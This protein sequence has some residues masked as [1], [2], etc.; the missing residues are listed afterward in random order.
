M[1][2]SSAGKQVLKGGHHFAD[3]SDEAA[4]QAIVEA[5]NAPA[6]I[7]DHL[8]REAARR[9]RAKA[10]TRGIRYAVDEIR[11]RFWEADD[12]SPPGERARYNDDSRQGG[13]NGTAG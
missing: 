4:A 9:P 13:D 12:P 3:A 8:E 5:M 10:F 7:E 11:A 6:K 1:T 2:F